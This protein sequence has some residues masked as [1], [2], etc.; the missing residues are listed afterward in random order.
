MA[1]HALSN[2]QQHQ[3]HKEIAKRRERGES[4][5]LADIASWAKKE[6]NF[7]FTRQNQSFLAYPAANIFISRTTRASAQT[8]KLNQSLK[9][10][11]PHGYW[12]KT[13]VV[14]VSREV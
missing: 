13:S 1:R 10:V 7:P 14:G 4:V 9:I 12:I 11:W 5:L 6:L 3:V 2:K 8:D